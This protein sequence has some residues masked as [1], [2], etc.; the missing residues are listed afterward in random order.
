MSTGIDEQRALPLGRMADS[1]AGTAVAQPIAKGETSAGVIADLGA[2]PG[3]AGY[4][5]YA[6]RGRVAADDQQRV[7][8]IVRLQDQVED[9]IAIQ[10]ADEALVGR[11]RPGHGVQIRRRWIVEGAVAGTIA[12][13]DDILQRWQERNRRSH[14]ASHHDHRSDRLQVEVRLTVAIVVAAIDTEV[15]RTPASGGRV[16]DHET[17]RHGDDPRT[18]TPHHASPRA[19]LLYTFR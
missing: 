14:F 10:V 12:Q 16:P 11:R 15:C 17:D 7:A 1:N 9:A 3:T 6:V 5:Q 2:Q 4:L 18:P 19:C 13:Q 8:G